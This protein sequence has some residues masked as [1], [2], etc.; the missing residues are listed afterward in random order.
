[1]VICHGGTLTVYHALSRGKPVLAVPSHVEQL[2]SAAAV[3]RLGVGAALSERAV[4]ADPGRLVSA[5]RAL[6][7]DPEVSTRASAVAARF[8]GEAALAEAVA[9]AEALLTA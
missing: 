3:E 8:S 1:L 9:A 2:V 6:L 7:G 4:D 5:A